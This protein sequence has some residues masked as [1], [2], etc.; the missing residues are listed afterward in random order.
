[1]ASRDHPPQEK[2]S[3]KRSSGKA[4]KSRLAKQGIII[5]SG[6]STQRGC[7]PTTQAP[8]IQPNE[9]GQL[10]TTQLGVGG[11]DDSFALQTRQA[12]LLTIAISA[13]TVTAIFSYY[14]DRVHGFPTQ[15]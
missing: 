14:L 5:T 4:N 6:F 8:A 9:I 2:R 11:N 1:M 10:S 12:K 7:L 3:S 15:F 13:F